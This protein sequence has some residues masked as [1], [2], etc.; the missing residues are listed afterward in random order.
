LPVLADT[1]AAA[2]AHASFAE[3]L[4]AAPGLRRSITAAGDDVLRSW[5]AR[6]RPAG[7]IR[8]ACWPAVRVAATT[9]CSSPTAP[10]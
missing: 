6:R 10:G 2:G 9:A 8:G 5:G 7:C 1:L 3:R 4:P